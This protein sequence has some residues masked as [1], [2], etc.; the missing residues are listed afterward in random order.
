MQYIIVSSTNQHTQKKTLWESRS[1]GNLALMYEKW[2]WGCPNTYVADRRHDC[3]RVWCH[4]LLQQK[5]KQKQKRNGGWE[6][7]KTKRIKYVWPTK[8]TSTETTKPQKKE[9]KQTK[10]RSDVI[11]CVVQVALTFLIRAVLVLLVLALHERK[12][13]GERKVF[14]LL[15]VEGGHLC[16]RR[17]Q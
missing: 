13:A 5:Q 9:P 7:R 3:F 10:T 8:T 6:K 14:V 16:G 2:T 11:V 15:A 17:G 1:N 4:S 12:L